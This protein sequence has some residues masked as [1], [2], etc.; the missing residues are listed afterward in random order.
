LRVDE[1]GT[2][3]DGVNPE[4]THTLRIHVGHGKHFATKKGCNLLRVD[5]VVLGLPAVDGF[6]VQGVAEHEG[7]ALSAA[8]IGDPIPGEDTLHCHRDI[9]VVWVDGSE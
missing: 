3:D 5:L 2:A 4:S 1:R 8:Q 9:F 6:H 7:D